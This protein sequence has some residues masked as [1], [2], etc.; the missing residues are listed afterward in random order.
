[1]FP[2]DR[3]RSAVCS[4]HIKLTGPSSQG[5]DRIVVTFCVN[6]M[7]VRIPVGHMIRYIFVEPCNGSYEALELLEEASVVTFLY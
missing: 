2:C 1:M 3:S 5:L 7:S 4:S 6:G